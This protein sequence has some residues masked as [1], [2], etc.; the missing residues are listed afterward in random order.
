MNLRA[1]VESAAVKTVMGLPERV[2]RVAAGR[3]LVLDGQ[4]LATD[5]HLMLRLQ[6]VAR[7]GELG[8]ADIARGRAAMRD[9]AAL[10]AVARAAGAPHAK[11]A[12]VELLAT[13][14]EPVHAGQACF[15]VFA[16]A[17]TRLDNAWDATQ[18]LGAF[19]CKR[20]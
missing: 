12:G 19:Q 9:N 4:T 20:D 13:V 10:V 3:P 17:A 16:E 15:R 1:T 6:Q 18:R 11:G 2:Q 5:L 8:A 7:R 14:G